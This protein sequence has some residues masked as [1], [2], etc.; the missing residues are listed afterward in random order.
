[1]NTEKRM[2]RIAGLWYL[3]IAILYSFS[4]IYVDSSFFVSGDIEQTVR[5]IQGSGIIFRLGFVSALAGHICFLFLVNALYRLFKSVNAHTARSMVILVVAGVSVAFLNRLNQSAAILLLDGSGQFAAFTAAQLQAL[6][7]FF[8]ELHHQGEIMAVLFW[9]L[10]LLPLGILII[11]SGFIPKSLGIALLAAC[12]C[13]L[14]DFVILFFFPAFMPVVD[15]AFSVI[16]TLAEV[17]FILWLL[18]AGVQTRRV[19]TPLQA[20]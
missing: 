2:A 1:M 12:F 20:G 19:K 18:I 17:S 6:A 3:A 15:S 9:G 8:L 4:M 7:M 11:R 10:W 5:N 14:S 16:E 13:Y